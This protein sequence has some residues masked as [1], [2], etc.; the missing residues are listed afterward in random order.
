MG[1]EIAYNWFGRSRVRAERIHAVGEPA[2]RRRPERV[3][4]PRS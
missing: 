3:G 4:E 2:A 1:Q